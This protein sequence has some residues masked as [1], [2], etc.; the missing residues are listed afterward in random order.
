MAVWV[1]LE[2]DS[3]RLRA[4]R[5]TSTGFGKPALVP[6]AGGK[7]ANPALIAGADGD[8]WL[9]FEDYK[10][11]RFRVFLTHFT[12]GKWS[13][14]V[15]LSDAGRNA[16]TPSLALDGNGQQLWV[17]WSAVM[18]EGAYALHGRSL[19]LA[20]DAVG[21]RLVLVAGGQMGKR[22]DINLYPSLSTDPAGGIWLAWEGDSPGSLRQTRVSGLGDHWGG[23][24]IN[25]V[26][27]EAGRLSEA[28]PRMRPAGSAVLSGLNDH[29]PALISDPAGRLW[30]FSRLSVQKP[31]P[32][33]SVRCT[34]L[35][36]G[37]WSQAA[38]LLQEQ[39]LGRLA[40]PA[41]AFT[42]PGELWVAWTSDNLP[43]NRT[44]G[45]LTELH[46]AR[47]EASV[48]PA[49]S[50]PLRTLVQSV[51]EAPVTLASAPSRATLEVS[52]ERYTLLSGN[53]HEHTLF[54]RCWVDGSDGWLQDDYR[55]GHDEEGYDFVGL[56]DHGYDMGP[57]EWREVVRAADFYD[58]AP[59]FIAVPG[60]EWTMSGPTRP[61]GSGH[62]NVFFTSSEDALRF[63]FDDG[64][65]PDRNDPSSVRI[66]Q[67]WA[68]LREKGI[69]DAIT[70]P[71]HPADKDHPVDWD[72]HDPDYQQVVE[73][74]Q[75]RQSA[76]YKGCPRQT[77]NLTELDGC[78]V[79]DALARGYRMGFIASGDHNSMG[80]GLACVWVK[81]PTRAGVME[82]LR[83]R[84]CFG[85]TGSRWFV[86]F[87]SDGHFMGEEY[88]T[89]APPHLTGKL[90]SGK[91][92]KQVTL[93]RQGQTILD[94]D[95]EALG[96][97][98][99]YTL[100]LTDE[101]WTPGVYYYL[102]GID[103]ANQIAWASPIWVDAL[104][105]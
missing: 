64:Q 43:N 41:V 87:R 22:P 93:F 79:Q 66:D 102:R 24:R 94:L 61:V 70:I 80:V 65:V 71:H 54:S 100:D 69:S 96:G 23:R 26:H 29:M 82:A 103:E 2:G 60:Y 75:G 16:Y 50:P 101:G 14:P 34:V 55:Y 37:G 31:Q 84:R 9:A 57:A 91:P 46:V 72:Y 48:T 53:L 92:L 58:D 59:G 38:D 78:F 33:W 104:S 99:E 56:T 47:C 12:N 76:E 13:K 19:D 45:Q 15:L 27:F 30:V 52:G 17:A 95:A 18:E 67:I 20:T 44:A 83:A 40:H 1:S 21:P 51:P 32:P 89:D 4:S 88:E 98:T 28:R 86:D 49:A 8:F 62:R 42:S 10:Q 36:A 25:V 81:E 90:V 73:L 5:W 63:T 11:A 68:L 74:F 7:A 3:F 77:P 35:G 97:S 85:T 105:H 6:S 39:P